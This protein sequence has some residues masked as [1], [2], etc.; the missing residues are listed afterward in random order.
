M[1][2]EKE[3]KM[4]KKINTVRHEALLNV[5]RTADFIEK[6]S[7]S[8]FKKYGVTAAQYN[9]MIVLKLAAKDL[10]QAQIGERLITSR[11]NV[12]SLIDQLEK[13]KFV[14]RKS[15]A[16]DRR[17]YIIELTQAGKDLLKKVEPAYLDI[18]EKKMAV[19]TVKENHQ[20]SLLLTKLRK[21][22]N[23]YDKEGDCADE[24]LY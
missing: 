24:I 5:V 17:V 2:L 15:V 7:Y 1:S 11:A 12:T 21:I 14:R 9:V 4:E 18:V 6:I 10:T 22:F 16:D 3:I 20:L 19:L 8:F 13:R 23:V